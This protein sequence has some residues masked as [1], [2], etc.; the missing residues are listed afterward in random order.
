M[1]LVLEIVLSERARGFE[2]YLLRQKKKFHTEY[3][4]FSFSIWIEDSNGRAAL[5]QVQM[6]RRS[7]GVTAPKAR[8]ESHLLR[9]KKK[10]HTE[11]GAFSFSIWIED[12]NGRAALPKVQIKRRSHGVIVPELKK[13][14]FSSIIQ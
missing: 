3:G 13:S 7:H 14:Q 12:S 10:F 11:Y 1:I 5:P 9:Q 6:K 4:A 2:S 8:S